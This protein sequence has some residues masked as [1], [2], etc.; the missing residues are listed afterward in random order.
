MKPEEKMSNYAGGL[1]DGMLLLGLTLVAL[2]WAGRDVLTD[3]GETAVLFAT[4]VTWITFRPLIAM[5]RR[6]N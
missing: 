3:A 4:T 5:A 1:L 6:M 2:D